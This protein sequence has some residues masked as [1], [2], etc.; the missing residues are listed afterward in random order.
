MQAVRW[1]LVFISF[2]CFSC[3]SNGGDSI[4][5]P[6]EIKGEWECLID[7]EGKEFAVLDVDETGSVQNRF[8]PNDFIGNS[9]L[10]VNMRR[11]EL[12]SVSDFITK[13]AFHAKLRFVIHTNDGDR[14][15]LPGSASV[16]AIEDKKEWMV[17][18]EVRESDLTHVGLF[19]VK[20]GDQSTKVKVAPPD[21]QEKGQ[22]TP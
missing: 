4:V 6:F 1:L 10:V 22:S 21:Q 7:P 18:L 20:V 16:Q 15:L 11:I 19:K 13:P 5:V 17:S 12:E 8:I 2:S 14:I 3:F 9:S